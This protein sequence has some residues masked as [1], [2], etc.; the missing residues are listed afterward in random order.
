MN[1]SSEIGPLAAITIV[2]AGVAAT[3]KKYRTRIAALAGPRE[4]RVVSRL[5][6]TSQHS[7]HLVQVR[8]AVFLIGTSPTGC[9]VLS[10]LSP[11]NEEASCYPGA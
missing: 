10:Q 5:A 11:K 2:L 3:L 9:S 1:P 8:E 4:M 7:L 6:L